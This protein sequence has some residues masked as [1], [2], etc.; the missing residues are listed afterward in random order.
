M[1]NNFKELTLFRYVRFLVLDNEVRLMWFRRA[2]K[3]AEKM[4]SFAPSE[5]HGTFGKVEGE[6]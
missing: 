5:F 4:R 2:I 3:I 6:M 1:L